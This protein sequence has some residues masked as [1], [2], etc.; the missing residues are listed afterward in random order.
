[1]RHFIKIHALL[2]LALMGINGAMAQYAPENFFR[3]SQ[4]DGLSNRRITGLIQDDFGFIWIGTLNGLNRYDG[5]S[6]K[7]FYHTD[8]NSIPD[9][10]IYNLI[11]LRNNEMAVATNNGAA[12]FNTKDYTVK[13]LRIDAPEDVRY[14]SNNVRD[15]ALSDDGNYLVS[16]GTGY[17]IFENSGK[18]I[19]RYEPI[20]F[21]KIAGSNRVGR[22]FLLMPDG[23]K[24]LSTSKHGF[25]YYDKKSG[26]FENASRMFPSV[27]KIEQGKLSFITDIDGKYWILCS[28]KSD[29]LVLMDVNTQESIAISLPDS[30][31]Y[32]FEWFSQAIPKGNNKYLMNL[33][34]KF[35]TLTA[36]R[37]NGKLQLSLNRIDNIPFDTYRLLPSSEGFLWVG[38]KNG[39]HKH[40]TNPPPISSQKVN[41]A[42]NAN[43]HTTCIANDKSRIF[44]GSDNGYIAIIK[45]ENLKSQ[46]FYGILGKNLQSERINYIFNKSPETI[47]VATKRGLYEMQ[48]N[49]GKYKE[50]SIG[51]DGRRLFDTT[52]I[53]HIY[54][55]Q[56]GIFWLLE[57][58]RAF[59]YN[60][61]TSTVK[62]LPIGFSNYSNFVS[63]SKEGKIW[64]NGDKALRW[65]GNDGFDSIISRLPQ[66]QNNS[67]VFSLLFTDDATWIS[68]S[69]DGFHI[70]DKNGKFNRFYD[71]QI[72]GMGNF[73]T[74]VYK[75]R[76][77]GLNFNGDV[78]V[79]NTDNLSYS[80][81]GK[82][83]GKPDIPVTTHIFS[84]D[85]LQDKVWFSAENFLCS[86]P[87]TDSDY[88][89]NFPF[90]ISQVSI[91]NGKKIF[92]PG[93]R[94]EL[95][96]TENTLTIFLNQINYDNGDNIEFSYRISGPDTAWVHLPSNEAMLINLAPGEYNITFRVASKSN[97]WK[98]SEQMLEIVINPP[99]WKTWWFFALVV[100]AG[101]SLGMIYFKQHIA[102]IRKRQRIKLLEREKQLATVEALLKGQE[103]ER[104]RLAKELHDSVGGMLSGARMGF[105]NSKKEQS[106]SIPVF[107][108]SI[109]QLDATMDELR[110]ITQDL[111]PEMLLKYG[112]IDALAEH[113]NNLSL[114][115]NS[116]V[117][118]QHLGADSRFSKTQ[119]LCIYRI[120]QEL[121]TNALKHGK[122]N[123]ILAQLTVGNSNVLISVDDDGT[124][125]VNNEATEGKGMGMRN[126]M[127]RVNYLN[128]K[129]DISSQPGEG[130]S[131]NIH[132]NI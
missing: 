53:M 61:Q 127:Q 92:F 128:G 123:N 78:V 19:A 38:G 46:S 44:L 51:K 69:A 103:E 57:Y 117:S 100:L 118:F 130:V 64:I 111:M 33:T 72:T 125:L 55:A 91:L 107:E 129:M 82:A 66:Q 56:N 13:Q 106:H 113:C 15:M 40:I 20:P 99:F 54:Q 116:K 119:E 8:E 35:C 22:Q 89:K 11:Y 94:I 10:R 84:F 85:T 52:N 67:K 115:S 37:L 79:L 96:H 2:L 90:F 6:F 97:K 105:E 104:T 75:K 126:L 29:S 58:D 14:W 60:P 63:E 31:I 122:A 1:M 16:T 30:L 98:P 77:Y 12:I 45:K 43:F 39:L 59:I 95:G 81:Y 17:Y 80:I 26:R 131:V 18:M 86:L 112:L 87:L 68:T 25:I 36:G 74:N 24:I 32:K 50:V 102:N 49:S 83:E 76:I 23:K 132:L 27:K 124:G 47:W 101:L 73:Y 42:N 28:K 41:T 4:P 120:V 109:K 3:Y 65:N 62:I 21:S 88:R 9:N 48:K 121:I 108:N 5:H 110:K 7:T 70:L 93:G 34:D 71:M 114:L